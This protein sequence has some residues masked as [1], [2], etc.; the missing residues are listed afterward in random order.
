ML[1]MQPGASSMGNPAG[2]GAQHMPGQMGG[3]PAQMGGQTMA[4]GM[5]NAHAIAMSQMTPQQI[6]QQQQ[7]AIMQ[8]N[9]MSPYRISLCT[10]ASNCLS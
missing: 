5:Q 6:Q 10:H 7:Q 1:A 4:G 2:M 8:H 3:M 9:R